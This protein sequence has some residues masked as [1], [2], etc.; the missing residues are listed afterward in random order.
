MARRRQRADE[1][2]HS[3][4]MSY[5]DMMAALLLVFVLIITFNMLQA[6]SEYEN[7]QKELEK[8]QKIVNEQRKIMDYQQGQLDKIIGVRKD[9]VAI[10]ESEF[11]KTDLNVSVHQT[12]AIILDSNILFDVNKHD[13]KP[14]GKVFLKKFI[15]KYIN[16]LLGSKFKKYISEIII[17]GH[18]DTNGSYLYNLKLSQER[19]MS[20]ASY[21]INDNN[22]ILSSKQTKELRKILTANGRSFSEP[23]PSKTGKGIDMSASRRVEFKF[24]LKNEEM[25]KEMKNILNN[26]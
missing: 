16:I 1:E 21:C 17:E 12:G 19:A 22:Y 6:K 7:K 8:Q 26:K 23:I 13:L 15:P 18:T 9:L 3:Y 4:W 2:E 24:R 14:A 5:S 20:V 10:L 11:S 25:I